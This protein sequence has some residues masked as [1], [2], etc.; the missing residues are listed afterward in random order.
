ML[1]SRPHSVGAQCRGQDQAAMQ[2]LD[3]LAAKHLQSGL[4]G[5]L[6]TGQQLEKQLR[7]IGKQRCKLT[8]TLTSSCSKPLCTPCQAAALAL[9]ATYSSPALPWA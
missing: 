6:L 4:C 1:V 5:D 3:A 2:Q 9:C 7:N 8:P